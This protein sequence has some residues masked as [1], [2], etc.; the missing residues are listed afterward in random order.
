MASLKETLDRVLP[1]EGGYVNDP[2]DL[3][4]ETLCG[5]AR[6]YWPK[7]SGWSIVDD[8]KKAGLPPTQNTQAVVFAFY[9]LHFW[10]VFAGD[11]LPQVLADELF[12]QA[13][14][15]GARRAVEHLQTALNLLNRNG[16]DWADILVD[17]D[18]GPT[19]KLMLRKAKVDEVIFLL[20]ALQS[21]YYINRALESPTQERFLRGWLSRTTGK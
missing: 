15:L 17:G 18:M 8:N 11:D 10:D 13:I 12:D 3:G 20:N 19:T 7:W 6:R 2:A 16:R 5:I 4:G 9:E 1:V 21:R 14:N